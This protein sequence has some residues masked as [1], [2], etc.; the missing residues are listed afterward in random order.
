MRDKLRS[1]HGKAKYA[2]R[3]AVA[4]L[5]FGQI[6]EARGIRRFSLQGMATAGLSGSPNPLARPAIR[7]PAGDG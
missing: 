5:P 3:K 6:E 4:E 7:E 2:R 1:E